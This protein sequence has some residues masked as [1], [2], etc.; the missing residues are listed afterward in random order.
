MTQSNMRRLERIYR[1]LGLTKI[2]HSLHGH[3]GKRIALRCGETITPTAACQAGRAGNLVRGVKLAML[4]TT[5]VKTCKHIL[6]PFRLRVPQIVR[7]QPAVFRVNAHPALRHHAF[8]VPLDVLK[9]QNLCA[10]AAALD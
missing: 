8:E 3:S 7:F 2:C 10:V 4:R 6:P 5:F 1:P 9:E